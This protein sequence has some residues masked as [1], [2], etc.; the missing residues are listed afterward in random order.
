MKVYSNYRN[1]NWV[2]IMQEN[3]LYEAV[4]NLVLQSISVWEDMHQYALTYSSE[5]YAFWGQ[6]D[7]KL[8]SAVSRYNKRNREERL[9]PFTM[10]HAGYYKVILTQDSFGR[11]RD[12]Y[13]KKQL[14]VIIDDSKFRQVMTALTL[15]LKN[16]YENKYRHLEH[17]AA[18]IDVSRHA[19][20]RVSV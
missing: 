13:W 1:C 18:A 20:A 3:K 9:A 17:R 10:S 12:Q 16:E 2:I 5:Y 14:R 8:K 6:L 19:E 11:M 15:H 4:A 7:D